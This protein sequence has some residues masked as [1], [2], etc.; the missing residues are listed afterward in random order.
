MENDDAIMAGEGDLVRADELGLE[1]GDGPETIE[2]EL[3]GEVHVVPAALKGAI[4]R[5]A[6]YTRKTQE[7][8]EHRRAL[9]AERQAFGQE[10]ASLRGAS[11]DRMRLAALD[12][13]IA[14]F[15]AV[16]WDAYAAEDPQAAQHLWDRFQAVGDA[17][18][19][20]AYAVSH[21]ES[22]EEMR[23]AREA[24]EEMAATGAKL[25]EEIDGWSPEVAAKLVEY[26]QA[27]GVTLEELAQM[28]DARLWKLLHKAWR[29]DQ[30][31]QGETQAEAV[32]VRPAVTVAGGGAGGGGV[33]DELATK[34]WMRRRNDQMTRG[35]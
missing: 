1:A 15:Q 30:A 16:D 7:L 33:R 10:A 35:R 24:A 18:E 29:A 6:D 13:Q 20:L 19:R 8:A 21:H 23:A 12:E 34:E 14:E 31:S 11:R 27:F 32:Q 26:G 2:V 22:R 4:L 5:Q 17:R 9:E 3:D 25:R 28:A